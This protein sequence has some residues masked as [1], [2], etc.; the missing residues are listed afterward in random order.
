M[1]V[2]SIGLFH[3]LFHRLFHRVEQ[4]WN[5]KWNTQVEQNSGTPP[6]TD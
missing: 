5:K 4:A 3:F 2:C 1:D 6:P